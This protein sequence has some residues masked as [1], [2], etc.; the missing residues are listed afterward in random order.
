MMVPVWYVRR[1]KFVAMIS[2]H[3]DGEMVA[4]LVQ[5]LGYDTVRGS[6]TRGGTGAAKQMIERIKQ[7][8]VGAMIC[9]GPRGP[10]FKMKAGTPYIALTSGAEVIPATA[11]GTSCWTFNS[12]DRFI[13]PKPF[14]RVFLLWGE[15]L[16]FPGENADEAAFQQK[17]EDALNDLTKRA[18]EFAA[19]TAKSD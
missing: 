7:G 12:W 8:Q 3:R 13:V 4:R 19:G 10:I 18:D 2:Q 11:A 17:L 1:K 6:S 15:P 16:P 9:D 14:S 5:K